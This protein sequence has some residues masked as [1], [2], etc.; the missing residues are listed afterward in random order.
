M[1]PVFPEDILHKNPQFKA[2]FQ[3]LTTN[4][5]NYDASTRLSHEGAKESQDVDKRLTALREDL[6]KNKI[7]RQRLIHTLDELPADL[8]EVIDLYL[9]AQDSGAVLRKD[10]EA[11]FLE[12][13]PLICKSLNKIL[14]EDAA[15]LAGMCGD[16]DAN[17]STLPAIVA[18]RLSHLHTCRETLHHLRQQSIQHSITLTALHRQLLSTTIQLIE[19]QK[20]GIPS[21]A[22]KAQARH[23]A[24]VSDSLE[25]KLKII[26]LETLER[27]YDAETVA[28]LAFYK[29]HLE[30]AK[31]RARKRVAKSEAELAEY[32]GFGEQMKR[33]V[34]RYAKLLED[35]DKTR[36]DIRRLR[37][38]VDD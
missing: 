9:S 15:D 21:R 38:S 30:D 19:R 34:A 8:R 31:A 27:T 22:A 36:A 24:L 16:G 23:L 13:L 2:I 32:E 18:S 4:K 3:D 11:F 17:P 29:E 10:D 5:L 26:L 14:I 20:H 12:G 37:G 1:I 25:G 35:I 33:D 7:I 6:A 28:A